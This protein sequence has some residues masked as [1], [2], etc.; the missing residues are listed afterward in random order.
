MG[1]GSE[2]LG[3]IE[4]NIVMKT[5]NESSTVIAKDMRSPD[6]GGIR[7]TQAFRIPKQ[8][9]G[10]HVLSTENSGRRFMVITNWEQEYTPK[11]HG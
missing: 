7:N 3:R 8:I 6:S 5:A 2:F 4:V 11:L 10:I 9:I 1:T